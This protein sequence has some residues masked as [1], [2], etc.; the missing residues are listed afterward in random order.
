MR[1]II[2]QQELDKKRKRNQIIL[3]I[4]LVFIMFGSVVSFVIPFNTDTET[5]EDNQKQTIE[6]NGFEFAKQNDFWILN[7]N[8]SSFIFKHNPYETKNLDFEVS[9]LDYFQNKPLSVYS[10]NV[11]AES[12]VRVNLLQFFSELNFL[13]TEPKN[14]EENFIIIKASQNNEIIQKSNC[15]YINGKSEDLIKITDEFI[16]R[17]LGIL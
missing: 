11:E 13:D 8:D 6:Y 7:L 14:C 2:S 1:K 12:E 10:E 3:G 17:L 5:I 16:F 4:F 9:S 15:I